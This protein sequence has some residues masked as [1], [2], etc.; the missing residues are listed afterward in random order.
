MLCGRRWRRTLY[1]PVSQTG[2][3]EI[4]KAYR[5]QEK[6]IHR[7]HLPRTRPSTAQ[8]RQTP[9]RQREPKWMR[10]KAIR[11]SGGKTVTIMVADWFIMADEPD[12]RES[13]SFRGNWGSQRTNETAGHARPHALRFINPISAGT[14]Q[15]PWP[16]TPWTISCAPARRN[17]SRYFAF[18]RMYHTSLDTKRGARRCAREAKTGG[19]SGQRAISASMSGTE[20]G[21]RP[22]QNAL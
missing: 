21:N 18:E 8:R 10:P 14:H 5:G 9:A 20:Y 12:R 17:S 6:E 7:H 19:Q 13:G 3:R 11:Q 16:Y 22:F 15:N 2:G 4:I 1:R